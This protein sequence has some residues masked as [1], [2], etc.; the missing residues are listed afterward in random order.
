MSISSDPNHSSE[1]SEVY[2]TSPMMSS[3]ITSLFP[4]LQTSIETCMNQC[5][6]TSKSLLHILVTGTLPHSSLL[7]HLRS[8]F[9]STP[10]SSF[11]ISSSFCV[12]GYMHFIQTFISSGPS[13]EYTY[14]GEMIQGKRCG[15]GK[16]Y[17]FG[18]LVYRGLFKNDAFDGV[19]EEL[20]EGNVIYRGSY[21]N[22]MREGFG[23]LIVS[24]SE[25]IHGQF[26]KGTLVEG[27]YRTHYQN[28]Q[29]CY[30]GTL[31]NEKRSGLGKEYDEQG[32][33]LYNGCFDEGLRHG[34]GRLRIGE[35]WYEGGFVKNEYDWVLVLNTIIMVVSFMKED[36]MQ[37]DTMD[38]EY[39]TIQEKE[40]IMKESS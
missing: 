35:N 8:L 5:R 28:G 7:Q 2:V 38:M 1:E 32:E 14:E 15:F 3:V 26:V 39:N 19:G 18:E 34:L 16:L 30:E 21:R 6:N 33:L 20:D 17:H 10:V 27:V 11:T 22:G 37:M 24:N 29:I 31:R 25:I 23:E 40:F 36:L 12:S 4:S 13:Q 9:P